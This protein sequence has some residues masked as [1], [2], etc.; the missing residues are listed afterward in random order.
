MNIS[1][2]QPSISTFNVEG[3]ESYSSHL[4]KA[5]AA[6]KARTDAVFKAKLEDLRCTVDAHLTAEEKLAMEMV[7][8]FLDLLQRELSVLREKRRREG[9][10]ALLGLWAGSCKLWACRS[11]A[12]TKSGTRTRLEVR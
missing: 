6:A 2:F 8:R 11:T 4:E 5:V 9:L 3:G 1:T 10:P 7:L 12:V